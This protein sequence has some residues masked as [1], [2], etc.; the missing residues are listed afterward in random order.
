MTNVGESCK[1]ERILMTRQE[2]F[3]LKEKIKD[4]ECGWSKQLVSR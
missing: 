2:Y 3:V 4:D 1:K